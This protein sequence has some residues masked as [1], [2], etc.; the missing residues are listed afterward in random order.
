MENFTI[1]NNHSVLISFA[2]GNALR[3]F[4]D[5]LSGKVVFRTK[6]LLPFNT[7]HTAIYIGCDRLGIRHF[8]HSHSS[9][10]KAVIATEREVSNGKV[11]YLSNEKCVSSFTQIITNSLNAVII[12]ETYD[13]LFNNCQ[14]LTSQICTLEKS[15]K[16]I[17]RLVLSGGAIL[18]GT[19][20]MNSK[21]STIKFIGF[22]SLCGGIANGLNNSFRSAQSYS[23]S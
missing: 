18:A 14:H 22:L 13:L 7:S 8:V 5:D 15:S 12:S 20:M 4:F 9:T 17:N 2:N 19:K 16:D 21:D 1:Y 23:F 10:G 3:L 11:L 6:T